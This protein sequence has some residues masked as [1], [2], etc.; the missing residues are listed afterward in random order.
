M[1][2]AL[3]RVHNPPEE[4]M[5]SGPGTIIISQVTDALYAS[6]CSGLEQAVLLRETAVGV[7]FLPG[8][9]MQK[10]L[11]V[12]VGPVRSDRPPSCQ[13]LSPDSTEQR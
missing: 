9:V 10:R 4:V 12:C 2:K 8:A 5:T 13:R 3:G 1:G 7:R 11:L 6:K